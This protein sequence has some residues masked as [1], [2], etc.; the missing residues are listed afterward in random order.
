[1]RVGIVAEYYRPW[2]GGISEHVHHQAEELERRGHAVTILTGPATAGWSDGARSVERLGFG[3][4]FT[5][6]GAR[7]RLVIGSYLLHLRSLLERHAFDVVHVHAPLDPVLPLAA[8]FAA[9]CPVVGTFHA[10]FAPGP[11]WETLFRRLSFVTGPAWR[12]LAARIAVSDEAR[13][14]IEHYFEG[15]FDVIPNGVDTERFDPAAE[16]MPGLDDARP[17]ILFVGRPDPRK[18]LPLLLEAFPHVRRQVPDARLVVVGVEREEVAGLLAGLDADL[19]ADIEFAGYAAPEDMPRYYASCDVFCS[20]ATGQESQGIVLLEAMAAGR[21]PVAF[22]IPGYRDVVSHGVDGRLVPDVGAEPLAQGLCQMLGDPVQLRRIGEA[23][24]KTALEYSWP[25]VVEADRGR[26]RARRAVGRARRGLTRAELS[27]GPERRRGGAAALPD[28]EAGDTMSQPS[29]GESAR[30]R[31]GRRVQLAEAARAAREPPGR[32]HPRGAQRAVGDDRRGG[33]RPRHLGELAHAVVRGGDARQQRAHDDPGARGA[34]VDHGQGRHPRALRRRHGV[35]AV[36]PLPAARPQALP[37]PGR[38]RL[39]RGQGLPE[40]ELVPALGGPG[41][42]AGR[43]VRRQ[44]ARGQGRAGR[45]RLRR[46]RAHG[47]ALIVGLDVAEALDRAERY[48]EAGADA[49][50]IHSKARGFGEVRDFMERWS[51][52]VP[53]ICVPTTYYSTPM[54]AFE[55]AGVSLVIWANH[56][57]RAAIGAMQDAARRIGATGTARD[58]EDAIAPVDEVFRL[59]DA[60]GLLEGEKRYLDPGSAC[61]AVVLAAS[62]GTGLEPLTRDRPK[63]MIPVNGT[64]AVVKMLQSMRAEGIKDISIVRGYR[65]EALASV[66][67]SFFENPD[68]EETGELGSLAAA[69]SALKGEVLLAYGDVVFRRHILHEL[70]SSDAPITVVVDGSRSVIGSGRK[71]D[72]VKASAPAPD[73]WEEADYYLER[74]ASDLPDEATDGEWVGMARARPEGTERLLAAFEEILAEPGAE[75]REL[76]DVFNRLVERDPRA[77]RVLY[78]SGGWI[79]INDLADAARSGGV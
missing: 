23:G 73:R 68:W 2:P 72:R 60:D 5:S 75:T 34:R 47:G 53:V 43:G 8:V 17:K 18:G 3:I 25:R 62:R 24:R 48:V 11:L 59:Q 19:L 79:D 28:G 1:M 14:S 29:D 40:D 26:V 4:Q 37:A 49:I 36:Q 20:P 58:L 69:R 61:S 54:G 27:S 52:P 35:R 39:H 13:R 21:P 65:P 56:M 71:A 22:A 30:P 74:I 78:V 38:R 10:N 6:N 66:G 46:R 7:S 9:S 51:R 63:C 67:A 70:L 64:P 50:L 31:S 12:R 32:A 57:L 77:V 15:E 55:R 41:A 76:G 33:R 16:R 44:A 42:R 45:P